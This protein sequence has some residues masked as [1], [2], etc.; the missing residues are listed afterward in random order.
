MKAV[1][2][3]LACAVVSLPTALFAQTESSPPGATMLPHQV[4][5]IDLAHVFKNSKKFTAL[6]E[7]LQEEIEST[8]QAAKVMVDRIQKLQT[9]L[10]EGDLDAGNA[11]FQKIEA[12]FIQAKTDLESYKRV[13]QQS[14]LRQ[15]ADI[16]KTIYL[17]VEDAVRRY[18]TYYK[19]TLILRFDRDALSA[20]DD[21]QVIMNGMNRQVVHYQSQDDIT[22]P[23]LKFLNQQWKK[24]E[25]SP[26]ANSASADPTAR[27]SRPAEESAALEG[28]KLRTGGIDVT[29]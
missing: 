17:D 8:D 23:V 27:S 4:G 2:L 14:F 26:S 13:A 22:E 1:V 24:A 20:E 12:E 9:R 21:P 10:S 19:Y 7:D 29:R 28:V 3:A 6:T 25:K 18:A 15:E 16:Y 5:L 11:E